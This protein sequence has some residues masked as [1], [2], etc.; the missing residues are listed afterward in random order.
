MFW[1]NL[2]KGFIQILHSN[3][4]PGEIAF[5]VSIGLIVGLTPFSLILKLLFYIFLLIFNINRA[6]TFLSIIIFSIIGHFI[7]P[8]SDKLGYLLLVKLEFLTPFWTTLY[9]TPLIPYTRF[10]NTL[11][12][13]SFV[14]SIIFFIP[15]YISTKKLVILYRT[16]IAKKVE[17]TKIMKLF[18]LSAIY[19]IYDRYR[20]K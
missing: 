6:A 8:L 7:D 11:V 19:S 9:N 14:V 20:P 1:I 17:N 10:N 3:I 15:V 12:L 2:V 16:N 5:G 18:K 4:T 13:G